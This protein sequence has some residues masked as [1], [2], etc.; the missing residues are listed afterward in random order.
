M[1][2]R[3]QS[4]LPLKIGIVDNQIPKSQLSPQT[5]AFLNFE[6][7][8]TTSNGAF[9]FKTPVASGAGYNVT[10]RD[11]IVQQSLDVRSYPTATFTAQSVTAPHGQASGRW[12]VVVSTT[13]GNHLLGTVI[14]TRPPLHFGHSHVG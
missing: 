6:P 14:F 2:A 1:N 10:N 11:R 7:L 4:T 3:C 8:P 13:P 9:T 12:A 5:L